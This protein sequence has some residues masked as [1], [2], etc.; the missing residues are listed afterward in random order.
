[1]KGVTTLLLFPSVSDWN[2]NS[3]EDAVFASWDEKTLCTLTEVWYCT[4]VFSFVGEMGILKIGMQGERP[5]IKHWRTTWKR[6]VLE[7]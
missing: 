4:V 7:G 3:R 6:N 1:M 2:W 5:S